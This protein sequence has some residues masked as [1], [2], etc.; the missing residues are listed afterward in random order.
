MLHLADCF[1]TNQTAYGEECTQLGKPYIGKC[2]FAAAHAMMEHLE[3][4]LAPPVA[5]HSTNLIEFDQ[6]QFGSGNSLNSIGYI[7]VPSACAGGR[8]KCKLHV[9]F[10][11]CQQT[12]ADIGTG[13][14]RWCMPASQQLMLNSIVPQVTYTGL[15]EVAEA[16]NIIV[17][18]PQVSKSTAL[19]ENPEGCFDWWGY[20]DPLY[21]YA[22]GA[23]PRFIDALVSKVTGVNF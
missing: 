15:N 2:K 20:T 14:V 8:S 10:H 5:Q 17:L 16:N 7:Y 3:G 22:G 6:S 9:S 21:A 18:Y 23:Q 1:P 13:Y 4:P 19:P 11:G 12:T